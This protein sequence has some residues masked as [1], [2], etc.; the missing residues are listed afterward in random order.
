MHTTKAS[1]NPMWVIVTLLVALLTVGCSPEKYSRANTVKLKG[2]LSDNGEPLFVEGIENATGMIRVGFHPILE[3][4]P[5]EE[6][7]SA[8][9][10][11]EGNFELTDGIEPGEYLITVGQYEPYPQNDLLKGK[12]GPKKS[13]I[14]KVIDADTELDIDIS[15]PEG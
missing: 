2:K 6:V 13:P 3:G 8:A 11:L 10:D 14:R 12:F 5:T 7:T 4:K 9:V 1:K 15:R